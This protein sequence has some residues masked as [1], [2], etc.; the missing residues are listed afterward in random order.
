MGYITEFIE[1]RKKA[2]AILKLCMKDYGPAINR[3][4]FAEILFKL[5]VDVDEGKGDINALFE[6]M[7]AY[8]KGSVTYI[9]IETEIDA[10]KWRRALVS[11][12]ESNKFN[13]EIS[14]PKKLQIIEK[15]EEQTQ[16]KHRI[17]VKEN[18]NLKVQIDALKNGNWSY[19]PN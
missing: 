1:A 7:D 2:K 6:I 15:R 3:N 11:Q 12:A 5:G 16:K 9:E 13:E 19:N 4:Q 17:E 10:A 18:V 8:K 14:M